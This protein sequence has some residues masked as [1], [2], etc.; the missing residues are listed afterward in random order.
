MIRSIFKSELK[1][2]MS[3]HDG[4]I[5]FCGGRHFPWPQTRVCALGSL[6]PFS[7]SRN[8]NHSPSLPSRTAEHESRSESESS[9]T[10]HTAAY[11]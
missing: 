1:R 3:P 9:L 4:G 7:P 10:M 6:L 8:A 11:T 5:C 2:H